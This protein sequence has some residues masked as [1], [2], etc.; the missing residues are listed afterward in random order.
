NPC[1]D[2]PGRNPAPSRACRSQF[3]F[4]TTTLKTWD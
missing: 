1:G 3:Q 4:Q 2:S